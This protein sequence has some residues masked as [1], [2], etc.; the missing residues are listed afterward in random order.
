MR[1]KFTDK[2]INELLNKMVILVD[3]REQANSHITEWLDKNK[4][5]YKVQK[6]DYGDYGCYLPIGSFEGQL[7]DIYFTDEIVIERK[8]CI[9]E[10]AMNLKDN[11][12][13]INEIK[14]ETIDLFGEKYLAKVL[15][16]DYCR[17]KQELTTLN[18]YDIKFL[19][20]LEDEKF[21]ENI[22]KGNFRAQ[23]DP[24]TLYRRLKGMEA[25]FNVF[26]RP[27]KKEFAGSEIYNTLRMWI[28]N[29]LVHKGFM[30][31]EN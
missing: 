26:I 11:K 23:Y 1:Y 9:D 18:K 13:N 16:T 14:Q 6:L 20:L 24:A 21:D 31:K 15:K 4:K 10:L 2:E 7:R 12:T 19:I 17:M 28:R 5:K 22:R 30:E 3:S 27:T 8:F 25:E 29:I